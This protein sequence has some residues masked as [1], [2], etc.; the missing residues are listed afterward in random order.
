RESIRYLV[1]HGMVDV[2]VTTAGGI[3]EDLIKCLAPTYIGDFNLRGRDLREN[4]INRS[5]GGAWGLGLPWGHLGVT[6]G[7]LWGPLRIGNLL[8]PNDNYCKFEDWL[9]PI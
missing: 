9:M 2:L 7:S 5:G 8:V 1:Q 6:S 4:G 3:E